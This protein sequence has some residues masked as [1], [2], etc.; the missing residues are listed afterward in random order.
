[1]N[2]GFLRGELAVTR[3]PSLFIK[4]KSFLVPLDRM[5]SILIWVGV[6]LILS[7]PLSW[8]LTLHTCRNLDKKGKESEGRICF[9]TILY[10]MYGWIIAIIGLILAIVGA[11]TGGSTSSVNRR[12]SNNQDLEGGRRKK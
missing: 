9:T 3:Q 7:W 2:P 12:R 6:I 11:V 8:L 1:M 4:R 10:V 5:N